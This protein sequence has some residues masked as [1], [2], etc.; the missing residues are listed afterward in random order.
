MRVERGR[1]IGEPTVLERG[2]RRVEK[3]GEVISLRR[4]VG[5]RGRGGE[6]L[7]GEAEEGER[8]EGGRGG[9]VEGRWSGKKM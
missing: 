8:L 6:R 1:G 2:R 4:E 7:E 3:V 9:E 5:G